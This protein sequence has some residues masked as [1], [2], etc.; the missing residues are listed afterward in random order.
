MCDGLT[1]STLQYR[2]TNLFHSSI[3]TY[4]S[5][6]LFNTDLQI[7]STLQYRL[8]NLFHSSIQNYKSH[9]SS[10]SGHLPPFRHCIHL[11][12]SIYNLTPN[13]LALWKQEYCM[14]ITNIVP[15]IK[16]WNLEKNP[17]WYTRS[18]SKLNLNIMWYI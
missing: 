1:C 4:K 5:V 9:L 16:I 8:T 18:P 17:F 6:P 10:S 7:C 12:V 15:R 14:Y 13:V 11:S 3:Q 2:F